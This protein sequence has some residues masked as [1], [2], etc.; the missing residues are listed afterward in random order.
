MHHNIPHTK[1]K[2]KFLTSILT[3]ILTLG[4]LGISGVNL[5]YAQSFSDPFDSPTLPTSILPSDTPSTSPFPIKINF[6]PGY[7]PLIDGFLSDFGEKFGERENGFMYGWNKDN[8]A[9]AR[10]RNKPNPHGLVYNTLTH[11]QKHSHFFWE[12]ALEDGEYYVI[13]A[14]G[15]PSYLDSVIQIEVEGKLVV[16]GV[17]TPENPWVS[18]SAFITVQDGRLTLS[19]GESALNNKINYLEITALG[20]ADQPDPPIFMVHLPLVSRR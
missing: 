9:N 3:L 8:R 12:I 18:G 20:F 17:P 4:V 14:G 7:A 5:T 6:Q 16:D 13:I 10:Y 1:T 2:L 11:L 15:D 19:S